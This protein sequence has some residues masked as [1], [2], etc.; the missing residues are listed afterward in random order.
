MIV[1]LGEQ[2]VDVSEE[3]AR[4]DDSSNLSV[5]FHW[6]RNVEHVPVDRAAEANRP[7]RFALE[8]F[9]HLRPVA[10]IFHGLDFLF[11]V[12]L[13]SAVR[14]NDG[15]TCPDLISQTFDKP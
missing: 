6:D 4:T 1:E 2:A 8:R 11:R 13:D 5:F 7:P 9:D 14:G 3:K 12:S 10:V 15:D